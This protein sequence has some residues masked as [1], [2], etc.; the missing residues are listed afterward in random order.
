MFWDG[1]SVDISGNRFENLYAPEGGALAFMPH[2]ES[3]NYT[4]SNNIFN[5]CSSTLGGAI[6]HNIY[7]I[8]LFNNL[9]SNNKAEKGGAIYTSS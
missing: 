3:V 9:F 5:N 2:D 1:E 4:I 6:F 7:T 8:N